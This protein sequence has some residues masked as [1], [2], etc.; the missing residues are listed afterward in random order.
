MNDKKTVI[1]DMDGTIYSFKE[2]SFTKSGLK[3]KVLENASKFLEDRLQITP[4]ESKKILEAIIDK[5]GEHISI[6]IEKEYDISRDEYFNYTW[7][8]NPQGIV[9]P[10]DDL[11]SM[12]GE[13]SKEH[14]FIILSD[15][16]IIWIKNVLTFLNIF[17]LFEN[18]IYSGESDRRKANSNAYEFIITSLGKKPEECIAVGDQEE[19]DIIPAKNLGI[20][21]IYINS[22]EKSKVSDYSIENILQFKELLCQKN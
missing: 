16:P 21:T 11:R 9:E 15:A 18:K 17:D 6:G 3:K 19:S 5:Y 1:F 8:V 2:G 7:N 12:L 22:I 14:D 10:N 13:I 4:E 20:T